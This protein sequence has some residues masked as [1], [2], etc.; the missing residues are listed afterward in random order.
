MTQCNDFDMTEA[1]RA[2]GHDFYTLSLLVKKSNWPSVVQEG[3]DAAA[4]AGL[5]RHRSD[6]F[7]AKWLQLRLGAWRRGRGVAQDVTP[8]LLREIDVDRCPITRQP[9]T[10]GTTQD[11]DWSVD[12]LNNDAAYA[13][14][15]LAVMSV[16]A[17]RA[18]GRLGFE[19]VH[20]KATVGESLDGLMPSEW[21]RLAVLMLGP[22]FATRPHDAPL[23]PLCAPLPT[24]S[25]RLAS[26][27]VQRLLTVHCSSH[28]GKNMLI[29]AFGHACHGDT[30]RFR[31]S[32]LA[33]TVHEGLK[34]IS[35]FDECWDVWLHPPVLQ[36]LAQWMAA[37][38]QPS[39]A[40]IAAI[41]G[42]L[43]EARRETPQRLRSWLL[44]S[45]G[46]VR[47][48]ASYELQP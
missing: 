45:R 31:L 15:N 35:P 9:L 19:Q 34:Q 2:L 28:T 11:T 21:L 42:Q 33:A 38:D 41:S 43:S 37:L 24:R 6:R 22:A 27:Q 32:H 16:K 36:A 1:G 29:R 5:H 3:F 40:Q 48:R 26:Q 18:K 20:L 8:H 47:E 10:H 25:V 44:P 23:L 30:A 46:F 14:S 13:A 4:H 17:N 7:V 39:W 12:R